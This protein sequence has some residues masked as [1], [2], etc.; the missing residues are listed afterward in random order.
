MILLLNF[1]VYSMNSWTGLN[2]KNVKKG[3]VNVETQ[4][5]VKAVKLIFIPHLLQVVGLL[6]VAIVQ[7]GM[8]L[9]VILV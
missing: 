4:H 6:V 7:I 2:A 1:A 9:Q 8:I 5:I 3:V